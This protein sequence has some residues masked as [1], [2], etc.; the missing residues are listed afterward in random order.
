MESDLHP[1]SNPRCGQLTARLLGGLLLVSLLLSRQELAMAAPG[2]TSLPGLCSESDRFGVWDNAGQIDRYAV[3]RLH[4]G[5]YTSFGLSTDPS[6]PTGMAYVQTVRLS[7]DGPYGHRACSKCPTWDQVRTV[8]QHNPGSLWLIGNEPDR[9]DLVD[10]DR[11]AELYHDFYAFLKSQD[12][13]SQVAIGGIVQP[14]P[15]RLQYLDLILTAYQSRYGA[16]MPVDVWNIHNYVLRE[17]ATGWG[18]GIPPGTDPELAIE[19]GISDHDNTLFWT[20]HLVAMRAWMRDRGYRD[21][22]LVISEFGILMFE[23]YDYDYPRVRDFMLETFDWLM[24]A[25]DEETGY[26]A[27]NNRLVQAW[28]W[29][30]LDE[31]AFEGFAT[32][33]HLFDPRSQAIT[34]LGL[35]YGAYTGPLVAPLAGSVDL[36]PAG[37][38][39]TQ[40]R[41]GSTGLI[42]ATVS[43]EVRNGGGA[44]AGGS[45]VRFERDGLPAGEVALPAVSG[46]A[47]ALAGITWP[48]LEPRVYQVSVEVNPERLIAECDHAN[49]R[50]SASMAIGG[51]RVYLPVIGA[52]THRGYEPQGAFPLSRGQVE[53]TGTLP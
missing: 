36:V 18:C 37:I 35:E 5:W 21:R 4:S 52:A 33:N 42:T 26:P 30:S 34:P 8:A 46:G 19:Y 2:G 1:R 10:A 20:E 3:A 17:G 29:Y 6:R 16:A 14:T 24:A 12:P 48:D 44:Q 51:S 31:D 40:A 45:V 50:L 28:A 23:I 9:Q 25:V 15:I 47:S 27:D 22:P 13:H 32:R 49:N 38:H 39:V 43:V 7:Q 53:P 41:V 11:Y